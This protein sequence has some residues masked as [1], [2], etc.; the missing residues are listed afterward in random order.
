MPDLHFTVCLV[1]QR[2]VIAKLSF[3]YSKFSPRVCSNSIALYFLKFKDK[4]CFAR[5]SISVH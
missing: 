1:V 3:V 2:Q 5:Q 4:S